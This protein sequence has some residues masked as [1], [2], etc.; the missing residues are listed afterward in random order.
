MLITTV[1][2]VNITYINNAIKY[3]TQKC[4]VKTIEIYIL[5]GEDMPRGDMPLYGHRLLFEHRL[6]VLNAMSDEE[7]EKHFDK[8][9]DFLE[10]T[11]EPDDLDDPT[12]RAVLFEFLRVS[13]LQ[14]RRERLRTFS[15]PKF[16]KKDLSPAETLSD[17]ELIHQRDVLSEFYE[18]NW[19][20]IYFLSEA[21]SKERQKARQRLTWAHDK[22]MKAE[23]ELRR[24]NEMANIKLT[25]DNCNCY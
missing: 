6:N 15:G 23:I 4:N 21:G 2:V 16:R 19:D 10:N 3:R 13:A 11:D 7:L 12:R 22:K 24:R 5:G 20:T 25:D 1:F 9:R 8:L 14:K 18:K 17:A